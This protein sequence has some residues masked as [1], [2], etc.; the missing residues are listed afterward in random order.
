MQNHR[1]IIFS[2]LRDIFFVKLWQH[3]GPMNGRGLLKMAMEGVDNVLQTYSGR[4]KLLRLWQY[5]A[6]LCDELHLSNLGLF[7]L[8]TKWSP[9]TP[10]VVGRGVASSIGNARL[11]FRLLNTPNTLCYVQTLW[12]KWSHTQEVCTD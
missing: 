4:D 1:M 8:L 3:C 9:A 6:I 5:T 10:P 7:V 2:T 11:V 12:R